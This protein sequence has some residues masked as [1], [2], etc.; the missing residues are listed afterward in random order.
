MLAISP[1]TKARINGAFG[2]CTS[3]KLLGQPSAVRRLNLARTAN[4]SSVGPGSRVV[5]SGSLSFG[6]EPSQLRTLGGPIP[7]SRAVAIAP[8]NAGRSPA[9]VTRG[10]I[11]VVDPQVAEDASVCSVCAPAS[12]NTFQ[13]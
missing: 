3:G 9:P 5:R 7:S 6:I 12:S 8:T 11:S 2:N 10:A 13:P 1:A 4:P